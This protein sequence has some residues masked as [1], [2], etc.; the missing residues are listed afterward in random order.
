[1]HRDQRLDVTILL[2]AAL[3]DKAPGTSA[4]VIRD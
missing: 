2:A 4:I 3:F 1:M